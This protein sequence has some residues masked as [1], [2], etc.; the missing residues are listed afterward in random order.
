[1][2][3]CKFLRRRVRRVCK[4]SFL[5][6]T[7][8]AASEDF[9]VRIHTKNVLS[10]RYDLKI[11]KCQ[12]NNFK[13]YKQ[14]NLIKAGLSLEFLQKKWIQ[15]LFKVIDGKGKCHKT[16][17]SQPLDYFCVTLRKKSPH[18]ELFW[19]A[20]SPHFPTF[21]LNAE[22]YGRSLCIHFELWKMREK[23]GPEELQI[24][25]LFTQ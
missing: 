8:A 15:N 16:L 10:H 18:L 4:K 14:Q 2:F 25:T 12:K 20:F 6:K 7:P 19:S 17:K 5:Y 23:C 3:S 9:I 24:R 1:M 21:G 13:I 22:R 11:K